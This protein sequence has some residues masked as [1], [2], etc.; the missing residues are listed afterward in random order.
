MRR[1]DLEPLTEI[2]EGLR[3]ASAQHSQMEYSLL[4]RLNEENA[5]TKESKAPRDMYS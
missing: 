1:K 3:M 5:K 2:L 4:A